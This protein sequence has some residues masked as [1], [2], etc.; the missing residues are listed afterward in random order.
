MQGPTKMAVVQK[1]KT[2]GSCQDGGCPGELMGS[3]ESW[4]LP[5]WRLSRRG[6]KKVN[7]GENKGG[8]VRKN[9]F[10]C[11]GF[12]FTLIFALFPLSFA[13]LEV[14]ASLPFIHIMWAKGRGH[15]SAEKATFFC[16][17]AWTMELPIAFSFRRC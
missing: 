13:Q 8:L 4:V 9:L 6:C 1:E 10:L 12:A 7:N 2:T 3:K 11:W 5:R 16:M 15:G 17:K 14:I